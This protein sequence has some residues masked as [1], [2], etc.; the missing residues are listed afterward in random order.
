M[1][2]FS[3]QLLVEE[4]Q[5]INSKNSPTEK[6]MHNNNIKEQKQHQQKPSI[7]KE[8]GSMIVYYCLF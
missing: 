3:I 2:R 8:Q 6:K 4:I 7:L 5:H 1:K